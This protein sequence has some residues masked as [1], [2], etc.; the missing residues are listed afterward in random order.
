VFIHNDLI[1]LDD[2]S[3]RVKLTTGVDGLGSK[4]L[5]L[6]I[7]FYSRRT[8]WLLVAWM[9]RSHKAHGGMMIGVVVWVAMAY[10]DLLV[11]PI[12][13]YFSPLSTPFLYLCY[14]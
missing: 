2:H 8:R 11:A 7:P 13:L 1:H 6:K 9:V 12:F 10:L 14:P 3:R 4:T 5:V